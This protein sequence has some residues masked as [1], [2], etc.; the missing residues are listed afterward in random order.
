MAPWRELE[1][2]SPS[3]ALVVL[4]GVDGHERN[5]ERSD[6]NFTQ[7]VSSTPRVGWHPFTLAGG[8][9][10]W[11][12]FTHQLL[13]FLP[14]SP[15][16]RHDTRPVLHLPPP[17]FH[18]P[19]SVPFASFFR[20]SA[21]SVSLFSPPLCRS[22]SSVISSSIPPRQNDTKPLSFP[23]PPAHLHIDCGAATVAA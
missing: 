3:V 14:P 8:W 9:H 21:R 23:I 20:V 18:L 13:L 5:T 11:S 7:L 17:P 2:C 19:P 1:E 16:S 22:T 4:A 10:G 15:G 12:W 6:V